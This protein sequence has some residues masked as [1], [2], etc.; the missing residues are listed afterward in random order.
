MWKSKN[1]DLAGILSLV[2]FIV[3]VVVIATLALTP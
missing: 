3:A 2:G 1:P